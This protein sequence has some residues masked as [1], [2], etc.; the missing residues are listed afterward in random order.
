M[1][2]GI[3][4]S[5]IQQVALAC[6]L[7]ALILLGAGCASITSG[8]TQNIAVDTN[9]SR[10]AECT[11]HNEKG[12]WIVKTPGSITVNKAGGALT[13]TCECPDG[14][15]GTQVVAASASDAV[16]GNILA[17][18]IIGVAVD[19]STGAAFRYPDNV[20]V[21]LTM[22]QY[23]QVPGEPGAP[24]AV[25]AGSDGKVKPMAATVADSERF[26]VKM[27]ETT[28]SPINT[29]LAD[30]VGFLD[31]SVHESSSY[32]WQDCVAESVK[33]D[34]P[35]SCYLTGEHCVVME[36][37]ETKNELKIAVLKPAP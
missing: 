5:A 31:N 7:F 26:P 2:R 29:R 36:Y 33:G 23:I 22:A 16:Y 17:G 20:V 9:P 14:T 11:A 34:K 30:A 3:N 12:S 27:Q 15:K 35:K 4:K 18:G 32:E 10:P 25:A 28:I 13:V 19:R 8:T 21:P 37:T 24:P 6:G 1:V